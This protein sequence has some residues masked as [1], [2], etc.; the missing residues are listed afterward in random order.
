M[1]RKP[2][3]ER[4]DLSSLESI[5]SHP[6]S[7]EILIFEDAIQVRGQKENRIKKQLVIKEEGPE[8]SAPRKVPAQGNRI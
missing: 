7:R 8:K 5:L 6:E 4:T 3:S 2:R 1:Y